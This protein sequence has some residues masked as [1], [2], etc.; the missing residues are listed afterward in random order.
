MKSHTHAHTQ[1]LNSQG[2]PEK[3][4]QS[5]RCLNPRFQKVLG[6]CSNQISLILAQKQ[7][8]REKGQN[9]EARKKHTCLYGQ[10]IYDKGGEQKKNNEEK[11]NFTEK[12][13]QLH[14]K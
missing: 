14:A 10:L 6:D 7:I 4:E 2:N 8:H 13:G 3:Q 5:Q 12:T 9:R 11:I 1:N